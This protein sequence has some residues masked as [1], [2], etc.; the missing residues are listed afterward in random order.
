MANVHF[1]PEWV[2]F[3][4]A[5][6]EANSEY[7]NEENSTETEI[8]IGSGLIQNDDNSL[9]A[10]LFI[11]NDNFSEVNAPYSIDLHIFAVFRLNMPFKKIPKRI[12]GEL[13]LDMANLLLGSAREM[14]ANITSRGPWGPYIM[15]FLSAED[16]AKDLIESLSKSSDST[17]PKGND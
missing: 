11:S 9:Q 2:V 6:I 12:A 17:S 10:T 3:P 5:F 14:I 15:P 16:L 4:K 13:A 7:D 8:D 1:K